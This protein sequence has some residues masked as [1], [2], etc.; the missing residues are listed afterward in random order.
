MTF[1]F[2][3]PREGYRRSLR[4]KSRA[5]SREERARKREGEVM[6]IASKSLITT[7]PT[8]PIYDVIKI[9]SK[10]GF[11]RV[12]TVDSGTRRLE[13][14]VTS[15]DLIDYLGGGEKFQLIRK[16][17][18]GNFFKAINEPVRIIME[19][20]LLVIDERS[21]LRET[22]ELMLEYGVGG[23]PI[24]DD[25]NRIVA[26]ITERDIMNHFI[27]KIMGVKVEELMTKEVVSI[28]AETTIIDAERIMIEQ[29]FRR[30]PIV[31][32]E[33]IIAVVTAMDIIRFFGSKRVF[34][35]L[36]SGMITQVLESPII[37]ISSKE[38]IDIHPQE[39]VSQA[40]NLMRKQSVGGLPVVEGKK[41]VGMITE[42][43]FLK[44]L[45]KEF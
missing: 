24:V 19:R 27:D 31:S 34:Q 43:D 14:L 25:K 8:V 20:D 11:R 15:T 36:Q 2:R 39:D 45:K 1:S 33:E 30:L 5:T 22:L 23:I 35:H 18:A 7:S 44:L 13:G 21:D 16:K 6:K 42:R 37:E 38:I 12:P 40:A 9:M 26:M 17:S 10:E 41:L 4:A 29:G 32:E 3:R 28:N